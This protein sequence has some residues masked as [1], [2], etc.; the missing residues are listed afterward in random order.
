MV[1]YIDRL[2]TDRQGH[3]VNTY[4]SMACKQR[5][6]KMQRMRKS[7][8]TATLKREKKEIN[9]RTK[10]EK[11]LRSSEVNVARDVSHLELH[12]AILQTFWLGWRL[13][14]EFVTS[15]ITGNRDGKRCTMAK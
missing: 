9:D 6:M 11:Q 14:V 15:G 1:D 12:R 2:G 3:V 4:V 10:D 13:D 5:R 8:E 7:Q